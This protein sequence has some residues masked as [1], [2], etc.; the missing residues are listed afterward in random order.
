MARSTSVAEVDETDVSGGSPCTAT[1]P[2][3]RV[4]SSAPAFSAI[5]A[6][7]SRANSAVSSS[8]RSRRSSIHSRG[9]AA[10]E[11]L[12]QQIV[13]QDNLDPLPRIT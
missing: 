3:S 1:P 11:R 4:A 10:L 9:V 6:V 12:A 8:G 7:V 5:K 2:V 13:E